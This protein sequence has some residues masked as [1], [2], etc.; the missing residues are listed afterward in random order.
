MP[1]A[2]PSSVAT[3]IANTEMSR[4]WA[5][6]QNDAQRDGDGHAAAD[7]RQGGGHQGA[8]DEHQDEEG[9]GQR[10]G[11]GGAQVLGRGLLD[12]RRTRPGRR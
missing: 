9:D 10:V 6:T 1:T 2:S 12:A 11:L 3:F 4:N 7:H 5:S 8:E